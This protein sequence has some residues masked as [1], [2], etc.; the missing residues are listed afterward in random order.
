MIK[1]V[2][3]LILLASSTNNGVWAQ[4][5]RWM[6]CSITSCGEE[7]QLRVRGCEPSP[8]ELVFDCLAFG[9]FDIKKK[10]VKLIV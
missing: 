1:R 3:H 10:H 2:Y 7:T 6:F 5:E 4:W 8:S 9:D